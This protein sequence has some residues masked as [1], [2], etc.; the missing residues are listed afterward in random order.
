MGVPVLCSDI[1]VMRE[2]LSGRSTRVVWFNPESPDSITNAMEHLI[3]HYAKY[4]QSALS[5]MN[6]QGSSWDAIALQY[7]AL[8][9]QAYL[10]YHGK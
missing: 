9:R 8:F 5:G 3:D 4:K 7:I 2:H 10:Q 6:D 1:P